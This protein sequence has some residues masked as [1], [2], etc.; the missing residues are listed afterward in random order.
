M[1]PRICLLLLSLLL[2]PQTAFA[3]QWVVDTDWLASKLNA[4]NIA[5]VDMSDSMQYTRFHLPGARQLPYNAITM[6]DK[7]RVSLSIGS[8]KII[9]ILGQLGIKA[10]MH[11]I[12]YDDIGGL[13]ASRLFWELERIGHKQVSLLDGGLVKWILEGKKVVA[14]HAQYPKTTYRPT[15]SSG[16]N[17]LATLDNLTM[18]NNNKPFLLDVRSKEEYTGHHRQ[19]GTGHIPGAHW[20]HWEDNVNF[21][22]AFKIQTAETLN[23][24]AKSLGLADKQQPVI[25]YCRSGHRAA[26]SYFTLRSLGYD[27][28]RLYDG[29]M[30]EY[31]LA[32]GASLIKQGEQP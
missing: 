8:K 24:R 12:I 29:S 19:K 11:I 17:N 10:E 31:G 16:Y 18:T 7:K 32:R 27:N 23:Q 21:E 9:Q 30:A 6:L 22:N 4:N 1:P 5:I 20:W 28:V 15:N 2:L 26:H 14:S 3:R 13:N 25:V